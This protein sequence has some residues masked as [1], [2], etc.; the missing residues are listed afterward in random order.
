MADDPNP[1][2]TGPATPTGATP[3]APPSP[4]P[5]LPPAAQP[6]RRRRHFVRRRGVWFTAAVILGGLAGCV[7]YWLM[8]GPKVWTDGQ[9]V[10]LPDVPNVVREVAWEKAARLPE[11]VNT[12]DQEYE[13]S[14]SPD[15]SELY[16][17]RGKAARNAD[18]YVSYRRGDGDWTPPVPVEG[19]NSPAAD[20]LGPRVTADN[21]FLLFY[22]NRE[23]G[24]GGYDIWAAPRVPGGWGTPF[25][26]GPAV[27]SEF[28]EYSPAPT[29]D[30]RRLFFATNR[31]AA[32]KI[33]KEAW[34]A[35]IRALGNEDFDLWVADVDESAMTAGAKP[36]TQPA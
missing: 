22:S 32:N 29:P 21:R 4:T 2:G 17:V 16:F 6:P 20:D 9:A 11:G 7:A 23:G 12:A 36:A 19:V 10:R 3:P 14:T 8:S 1:Q 30:G 26:L 24:L 5:P 35:T 15:G 27:N 34:R 33:Q 18:I 28:D 13:P 31:K 25:N